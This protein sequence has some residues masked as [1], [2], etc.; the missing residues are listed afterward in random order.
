MADEKPEVLFGVG[1][2]TS[3]AE[4]SIKKLDKLITASNQKY[5][6]MFSGSAYTQKAG[7]TNKDLELT[8]K[9]AKANADSNKDLEKAIAI[10]RELNSLMKKASGSNE[11]KVAEVKAWRREVSLLE[12][13]YKKI[14][15]EGGDTTAISEKLSSAYAGLGKAL[16]DRKIS[17]IQKLL[18]TFKR[19][20]FYRLARRLFQV[21]EQGFSQGLDDLVKFDKQT[22]KTMSSIKSSFDKINSSIAL[23][24]MPLIEVA[25]P[26]IETLSNGIAD[27]ANKISMASAHMKGLSEYTRVNTEYMKDLQQEANSTLLSFDKFE[28]LSGQSNPFEIARIKP[29]DT[30]VA[31][32]YGDTIENVKTILGKVFEVIKGIGEAVLYIFKQLEPH[33]DDLVDGIL[34]IVNIFADIIVGISKLFVWLTKIIDT[35]NELLVVLGI[36]TSI[37]SAIAFATG[38]YF[39]GAMILGGG[40]FTMTSIGMSQ[41]ADGGVP[42]KGSLFVAGEAG[43]ELVTTMPSGQTGVTNITQFKQAMVEAIYECADVFQNDNGEVVLKLDG[44]EIA[45][46]KRF[47]SELN[48]TNSGLHLL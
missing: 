33:L 47:K 16:N 29:E 19:V 31:K 5:G 20:G 32:Q 23:M 4:S 8:K 30:E 21:I 15:D 38:H 26:I 17:G 1:A 45:R 41:F 35:K 37:A 13:E 44:A 22:N 40:L 27:F 9:K 25:Q 10:T 7:I 48:R 2:D 3:G 18:N 12:K 46:S 6:K 24:V 28:S 36:I 14:S 11:K 34:F 39:K 43:A 42:N